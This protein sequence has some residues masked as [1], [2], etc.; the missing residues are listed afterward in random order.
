MAAATQQDGTGMRW[1]RRLWVCRRG[2]A[3]L[4][5]ALTL[6]LYLLLSAAVLEIGVLLFVDTVLEGAASDAAREIRTGQVQQSGDPIAAFRSR[7]CGS[8]Y[9][10]VDCNQVVLDVRP[11]ASFGTVAAPITLDEDGEP[12]DL[13][14]TPGGSGQVT[15]VRALYRWQFL[16]PMVG[17]V[18]GGTGNSI[19]LVATSVFRNEPYE[20]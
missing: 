16:T 6:P 5:T 2:A 20:L 12:T 3:A 17:A 4:E 10:V 18:L 11:F 19:L 7:L 9:V 8:L 1:W 14:F 13:V 15:L